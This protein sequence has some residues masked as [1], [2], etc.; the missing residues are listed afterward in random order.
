L[1]KNFSVGLHGSGKQ[2]APK[3]SRAQS[4]RR[5]QPRRMA[6]QAGISSNVMQCR[7]AGRFESG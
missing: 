6:E 1:V 2:K 3:E 4:D 5:G 7:I